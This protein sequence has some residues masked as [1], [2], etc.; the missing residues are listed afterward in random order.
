M[1]RKGQKNNH[2]RK[3]R[4]AVVGIAGAVALV[5]AGVWWVNRSVRALPYFQVKEIQVR[6]NAHVAAAEVRA[7]L[8]LRGSVSILHLDLEDLASKVAAHPWIRRAAIERRLP[9]S[10]VVTVEERQPVARLA[11][12]RTAYLVSA[13]GVVVQ[14][15]G[16]P[17]GPPLP[18]VRASWRAEY[19]VGERI[20]D[21]RLAG[22]LALL[23]LLRGEPVLREAPIQELVVE[24]DGN[25][26]LRPAGSGVI[27]RFGP[28]EQGRQ[29]SRLDVAL[30]HRG[31]GLE[32]V[33]YA[34]LRFPG[35][36]ILKPSEKGG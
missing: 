13:D 27:V 31:H 3:K 24:T 32:G 30:R 35:R 21:P 28:A 36:V 2:R 12:G 19:R 11:A 34:D 9:V 15:D 14:E 33:T 25:Y 7:R 23:A 1:T 20:S 6:G 10:L 17:T 16:G 22:G 8:G 26:I 18:T 5:G 29:L 4:L